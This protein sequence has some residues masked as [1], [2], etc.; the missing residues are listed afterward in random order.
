MVLGNIIRCRQYQTHSTPSNL[1]YC[2]GNSD[3]EVIIPLLR[4]SKVTLERFFSILQN[5]PLSQAASVHSLKGKPPPRG[6]SHKGI[7][8]NRLPDQHTCSGSTKP[9][10]ELKL[11]YHMTF[12]KMTFLRRA[13]MCH[14]AAL[15]ICAL[16][17]MA[18]PVRYICPNI[19][20]SRYNN[21]KPKCGLRHH[22]QTQDFFLPDF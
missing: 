4:R 11:C 8:S 18:S 7:L 21:V 6:K 9:P 2:P 5:P 1:L 10:S 22:S 20:D 19:K 3:G 14:M 16:L 15:W 13:G 12:S 17:V